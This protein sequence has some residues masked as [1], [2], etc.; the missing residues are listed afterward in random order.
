MCCWRIQEDYEVF[1]VGEE[2]VAAMDAVGP[3][4]AREIV[5]RRGR[6]AF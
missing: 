6:L 5:E 2:D 4:G 3:G 1:L